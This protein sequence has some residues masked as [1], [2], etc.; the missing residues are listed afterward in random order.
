VSVGTETSTSSGRFVVTVWDA[1][2][3]SRALAFGGVV[4][5]LAWL[6]TA[7]TDEGGVAWTERAARTLPLAPVCAAI[8][9]W[10]G[11][12]RGFA[13]GEGRALAALGRA[14]LATSAAAVLGGAGVA[15]VAA[16]AMALS[17]QVDVSGFFPVA[18]APDAYVSLGHGVFVDASSGYRIEPDGAITPPSF[19]APAPRRRSSP[20]PSGGRTAAAVSTG[21]A[22]LA[23]PLLAARAARGSWWGKSWVVALALAASTL[24]FHAAAAH[25]VGAL[26][27]TVPPLV[28][29]AFAAERTMR[30]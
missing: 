20:V 15:F 10:L 17:G 30:A 11:Q 14:P 13:R 6:V 18:R 25:L 21:L 12:A 8:G 19:E 22:G 16:A 26:A 23:L 3:A 5:V 4:L 28:L 27:A 24:L 1:R 29:L 7:A 2:E 9:T